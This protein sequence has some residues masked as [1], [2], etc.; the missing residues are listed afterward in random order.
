MALNVTLRGERIRMEIA[1]DLIAYTIGRGALYTGRSSTVRSCGLYRSE[2]A[3]M[4][5][6]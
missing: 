1:V 5:K 2:N 4:S 6:R 3:G